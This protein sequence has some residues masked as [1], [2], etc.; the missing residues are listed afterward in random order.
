MAIT[1]FYLINSF[2]ANLPWVEC[3]DEWNE[4]L[5]ERNITC[6]PSKENDFEVPENTTTASSSELYFT[7]VKRV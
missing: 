3:N 5:I 1:L 4:T 7:Y 2:T 6:V